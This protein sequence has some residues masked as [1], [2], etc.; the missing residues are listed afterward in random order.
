M[1]IPFTPPRLPFLL[2]LLLA[3]L[4]HSALLSQHLASA[5]LGIRRR[6]TFGDAIVAIRSHRRRLAGPATVSHVPFHR[7]LM[8]LA[9]RAASFKDDACSPLTAS[10]SP[11]PAPRLL[12][13][14][15]R[16]PPPAPRLPLPASRSPVMLSRMKPF[17]AIPAN[18]RCNSDSHR[19]PTLIPLNSALFPL[20]SPSSSPR[21]AL[22][23]RLSAPARAA[24]AVVA[25]ANVSCPQGAACSVDSKYFPFC[26]CDGTLALIN[27]SCVP[28]EINGSCVP[29]EVNGSCVPGEVN[30]SCVPGEVN[31]SCV[32][33]VE[34][35]VVVTSVLLFAT[36][37]YAPV[38]PAVLR[39]AIPNR[40]CVNLPAPRA[41]NIGSLRILWSV[42]DGSSGASRV[43]CGKVVF[44][45][46]SDCSGL[47]SAFEVPGG[48]KKADAAKTTYAATSKVAA[49]DC[50]IVM[51]SCPEVDMC[52]IVTC[53]AN[54]NC[55]S[56][57]G[58]ARCSCPDPCYGVKCPDVSTC[59]V[60][61]GTA[62]CQ[63][64][65]PYAR[66]IDGK[67]SSADLPHSDYLDVHNTA[68]AAVGAV[69]LVWDDALAVRAQAWATALT[70]TS[71][72][73]A[74]VHG[75][76]DGEGQNLAGESPAGQLTNGAAAQLWVD[77]GQW[78]NVAVFPDG[79][80][81]GQWEKCGHYTQ[82][83][84]NNTRTVGC[85]KASCGT[86]G[87]VWACHYY[88]P[89][90][91]GGQLPYMQEPCFRVQC[92][93]TATCSPVDG[94]P[95]CVCGAGQVLVNN[96][97]CLSDPCMEG[98]CPA[99]DL[100]CDGTTGTAQCVCPKGLLLVAPNTCLALLTRPRPSSPL[101]TPPHPSAP[102]S[103]VGVECPSTSRCKATSDGIPFCACPA[104]Y[105]LVSGTCTQ[106]APATV[107]TSLVLF[108]APNFTNSPA[109]L[110]PTV[111]R[112][113]MP[114]SSGADGCVNVPAP[115]AGAVGSIKILWDAPDG[116]GGVRQVCGTMWLWNGPDCSGGA[117]GWGKPDSGV[118]SSATTSGDR[119]PHRRP[120]DPPQSPFKL[121]SCPPVFSALPSPPRRPR[122]AFLDV[123]PS[124]SR[125]PL[126]VRPDARPV[127][128][129]SRRPC[130]L[131]SLP[132]ALAL[133]P[134]FPSPLRSPLPSRRP[135]SLPSLPVALA[136][137]PLFP[138]PLLSPLPSRRPCSLPSLP[139]ALALSPPFPSPL[140]SPLSSRRPCSLPSL[141][142]A[143]A[144]S[145]L[146]PSPLLSPLPS[147]HPCSLPSLHAAPS[148]SRLHRNV[149]SSPS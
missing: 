78:Y 131:P 51:C 40:T 56:S 3:F 6:P 23:V 52:T 69:P 87:D 124:P 50:N 93:S 112:A 88:P 13:P 4:L 123:L 5:T 16:S 83:I 22:P 137:S 122:V 129:S 59:V 2:P 96:S 144:L 100:V 19:S 97:Q 45:N 98:S 41:G 138:S 67:C 60:Q 128:L 62:V 115:F 140:L 32:P 145:S 130:A 49:G 121:Q 33:A 114:D 26:K 99:G 63:C 14:A 58:I 77:E 117:T 108:N 79:C 29:G 133:S 28:G 74:L 10:C 18:C 17:T 24:T 30:G 135:C 132:V 53:P 134:L 42:K 104:S 142:V 80:A 75:G 34:G 44:W 27:G 94:N 55:S 71:Y 31:G 39:G 25:C 85:G 12:L 86:S 9:P 57:A 20:R 106:A 54:C 111:F 21:S 61:V 147:R 37:K 127:A 146:F 82:V 48:W 125:R 11:P 103:C 141:P 65:A 1:T 70:N 136:L 38:P 120:R 102:P 81:G 101:L 107:T 110:A 76:H 68:R 73:C 72:N 46:Q 149:L 36:A 92:P 90:N 95:V 126:A 66:L 119:H 43:M 118:T 15:S 139:V 47:S 7:R 8:R 91:Y 64:P 116:A 84:W 143:L 109:S 148:P 89:G 35:Q 105:S 113:A